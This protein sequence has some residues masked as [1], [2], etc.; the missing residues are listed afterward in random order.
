MF[1]ESM[2]DGAVCAVNGKIYVIGPWPDPKASTATS[3]VEEYDPKTEKWTKKT[4]MPTIRGHHAVCAIDGKIYAVGGYVTGQVFTSALEE[5]DPETDKWTKKADMPTARAGLTV[6]AVNGKLY[7]IGGSL[8]RWAKGPTL[9]TVEEYDPET[10]TWKRK[11][12][13]PTSRDNLAA[14]VVNGKIYVI[15]GWNEDYK[16]CAIVEEYD[17]EMDTWRKMP[18]MPTVRSWPSSSVVDGKIYVMGGQ[19]SGV[20]LSNVEEYTPEA[21]EPETVSPQG[22]LPTKWGEVKSD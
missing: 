8:P 15:G 16:Q 11:A 13:M 5:Y 3:K 21:R 22:K 2:L 4:S 20:V 14:S 6:A 18:D 9:S 7:A 1:I 17:P 19:R 10:D 12:D